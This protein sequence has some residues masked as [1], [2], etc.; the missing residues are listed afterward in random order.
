MKRTLIKFAALLA[1]IATLANV[2]IHAEEPSLDRAQNS[3]LSQFTKQEPSC[4]I[5]LSI[6]EQ[7]EA[8]VIAKGMPGTE[9]NKFG[10][11]AVISC[12]EEH[13]VIRFDDHGEKKFIAGIVLPN[14]KK[15]DRTPP[16]EKRARAR[17]PK[18][19][20]AVAQ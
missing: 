5:T 13:I 15:S 11:G 4:N 17:K 8:P 7:R 9:H 3:T 12:S 18:A 19:V 20:P 10:F 14:L 2:G 16:P 1:S 6:I